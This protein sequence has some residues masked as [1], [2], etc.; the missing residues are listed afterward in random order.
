[1]VKA[2][3]ETPKVDNSSADEIQKLKNENATL[4]D[5]AAKTKDPNAK[6][7]TIKKGNQVHPHYQKN[8]KRIAATIPKIVAT[9]PKKE[10]N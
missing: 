5:E 3:T 4:K 1:M 6:P 9:I 10:N 8:N 7:R 2:K